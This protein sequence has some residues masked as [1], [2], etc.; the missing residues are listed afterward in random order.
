MKVSTLSVDPISN[1]PVV[2]LTGGAAALV[3]A[4]CSEDDD[5]DDGE[6]LPVAI[7][8]GEVSAIAAEL[9]CI[10]LERPTTHRLMAALLERTGAQVEEICI[11]ALSGAT[12]YA[13]IHLRLVDGSSVVQD[14]RPSD[15]LVLALLSGADIQVSRRV[16][17]QLG[18][19]GVGG[20]GCALPPALVDPDELGEGDGEPFGK[21]KM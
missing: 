2:L 3:G 21:W 5:G 15:A 9:G 10:E 14:S 12:L 6:V 11:H 18:A 7:G 16:L 8:L 19:A 20:H 17:E 1:L 13:H 4:D